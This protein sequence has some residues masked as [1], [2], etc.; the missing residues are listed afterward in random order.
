MDSLVLQQV[1]KSRCS[2]T[3]RNQ[4]W[5]QNSDLYKFDFDNFWISDGCNF[6]L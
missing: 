5:M 4:Y 2:N 6:A 1:K 3:E